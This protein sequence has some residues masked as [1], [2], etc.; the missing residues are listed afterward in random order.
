MTMILLIDNYD[1]FTYNLVQRRAPRQLA[2]A[3]RAVRRRKRPD[4]GT[5]AAAAE[6]RGVTAGPSLPR[7]P[8]TQSDWCRPFF[9]PAGRPRI[10]QRFI[11]GSTA[12]TPALVPE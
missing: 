11:A 6:F 5:P 12:A 2:A 1:S 7:H 4:G 8:L 3:R 10:A 9:V